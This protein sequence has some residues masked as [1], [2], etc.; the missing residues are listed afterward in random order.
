MLLEKINREAPF[1]G[2]LGVSSNN[3]F[4]RINKAIRDLGWLGRHDFIQLR[5]PG[6]FIG[7]GQNDVAV[8]QQPFALPGVGDVGKLVRGD[9]E[10]LGKYLPVAAGLVEHVDEIAVF[11]DVLDF[12]GGE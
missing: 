8:E 11:K 12:T 2:L 1:A 3:G 6:E 9:I 5:I 7:K 4:P 10:L